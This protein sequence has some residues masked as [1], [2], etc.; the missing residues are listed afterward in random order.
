VDGYVVSPWPWYGGGRMDQ[1]M[2][3]V[4]EEVSRPYGVESVC[5]SSVS[6]FS[7]EKG[8]GLGSVYGYTPSSVEEFR[9]RQ[10]RI[11]LM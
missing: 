11:S 4:D 9:A 6:F 2:V 1:L 3:Q 10:A 5:E 7:L 8:V